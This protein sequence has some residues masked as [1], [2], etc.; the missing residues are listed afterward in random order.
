MK[1]NEK[2]II[3]MAKGAIEER[4]DYEMTKIVE[5]IRD[6][7][8]KATAPRELTVK[9]KLTPDDNR[10]TIQVSASASSKLQPTTPIVTSLYMGQDLDGT[11]GA[12]EMTPH[13]P[14]QRFADGTEQEEP[15]LLKLIKMA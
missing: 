4:I 6:E 5:N 9:I 1:R 13:I 3:Q 12:V 8:T 11:I 14:G 10:E 15:A 2:S 7:S